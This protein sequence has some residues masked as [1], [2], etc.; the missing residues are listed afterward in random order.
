MTLPFSLPKIKQ[1][2]Q[3]RK[4]QTTRKAFSLMFIQITTQLPDKQLITKNQTVK[5]WS[6]TPAKETNRS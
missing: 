2:S 6:Q 5:G 3:K 1:D 4:L